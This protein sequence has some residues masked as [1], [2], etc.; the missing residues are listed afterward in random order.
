MSQWDAETLFRGKY[1]FYEESRAYSEEEFE[2]LRVQAD[3][4]HI[5]KS[6]SLSRVANGEFL[7]VFIKYKVNKDFVPIEVTVEKQLGSQK[8]TEEY[9]SNFKD[10]RLLYTFISETGAVEHDM[11]IP[12]KFYICTPM[13][14]ATFIYFNSKK[15]D[16]NSKNYY[17]SISADNMW[18]CKNAPVS[19]RIMVESPNNPSSSINIGEKNLACTIY[20]V[21]DESD[22]A[23]SNPLTYYVS[24]H[25]AIPYRILGPMKIK[26]EV[27]YLNQVDKDST[28]LIG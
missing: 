22:R 7:K 28:S 4:S 23:K 14:A 10:Q 17:T 11:G 9:V 21:F 16:P 26:I 20:N 12:S 3:A 13:A 18:E 27:N 6:E 19:S 8:V 5:F 15:Y 1:T 25:L 2:V 24:K